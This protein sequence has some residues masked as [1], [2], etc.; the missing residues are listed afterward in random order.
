MKA[1]I[2]QYKETAPKMFLAGP[3]FFAP[4]LS[5]F[6]SYIERLKE[7]NVYHLL[8][9]LTDGT[10]HDQAETKNLLV[11]LSEL[12]CSVIIFGLGDT[13]DFKATEE[14]AAVFDNGLGQKGPAD[15]HGEVIGSRA[16][17]YFNHYKQYNECIDPSFLSRGAFSAVIDHFCSYMELKGIT[18]KPIPANKN[19]EEKPRVNLQ[20]SADSDENSTYA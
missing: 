8:L 13:S 15:E 10:I 4:I 14:L 2:D 9:L 16:L 5:N 19:E 11:E 7:T 6:K 12:P 3:T 18:P 20:Q 17:V 1:V